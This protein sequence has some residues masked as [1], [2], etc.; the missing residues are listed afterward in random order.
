MYARLGH[1]NAVIWSLLAETTAI[2]ELVHA[3]WPP[4]RQPPGRYAESAGCIEIRV[5]TGPG[6]VDILSALHPRATKANGWG[7]GQGFTI[8]G[9][10]SSPGKKFEHCFE[11]DV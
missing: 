11:Q 2:F 10:L 8:S 6:N 9:T 4:P 5:D 1:E 3:E 7:F